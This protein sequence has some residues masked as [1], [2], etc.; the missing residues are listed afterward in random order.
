VSVGQLDRFKDHTDLV[1]AEAGPHGLP[2][3]YGPDS[4]ADLY[5]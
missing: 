1:L 2:I 4:P 3:I 5:H